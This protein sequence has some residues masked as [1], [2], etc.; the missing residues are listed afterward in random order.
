VDA[1]DPGAVH[2]PP[3]DL[4]PASTTTISDADMESLVVH[5]PQHWTTFPNCPINIGIVR[6]KY[7][8]IA[9][10]YDG[11]RIVN[12]TMYGFRIR[13]YGYQQHESKYIHPMFTG[14]TMGRKPATKE[15]MEALHLHE[16]R[17][18]NP[19]PWRWQPGLEKMGLCP[20]CTS[21][22]TGCPRC[23]AMPVKDNGESARPEDFQYNPE[24]DLAKRAA[25]EAKI[26]QKTAAVAL[27]KRTRRFLIE[28]G[29]LSDHGSDE[30][31]D[32]DSS[33]HATGDEADEEYAKGEL[34][35]HT[36]LT[37]FEG[38][39]LWRNIVQVRLTVWIKVN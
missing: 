18:M 34:R 15:Q 21:G 25:R 37:T 6:Q 1:S 11:R 7:K 23:F 20:I 28:A 3:V 16:I 22:L 30:E 4:P 2:S 26:T 29:V 39:R 5:R 8:D 32:S 14:Y 9:K 33:G 31:Q 13:Y 12:P 27:K 24:K 10:Q 19:N 17:E 35:L 36:K 38:L